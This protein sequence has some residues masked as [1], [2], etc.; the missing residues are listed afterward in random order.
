MVSRSDP[1]GSTPADGETGRLRREIAPL[2]VGYWSF[3]QYWGVWVIL[4]L[5]FLAHYGLS[6]SRIGLDY[7]VLSITSVAVMIFLTPRLQPLALATTVPLALLALGVGALMQATGADSLLIPAFIVVGLGNGLIDVFMNVAAQQIEIRTSRPVLQWMHASYAFGGVT[8]GLI[9]GL[10][11]SSGA[12]YRWAL[13]WAAAANIASGI[14]NATSGS[15]Q[16][17]DDRPTTVVS[18]SAFR[19]APMLI[20]PAFVVLSAFLVEGS[21]DTWSG[22]FLRGQLRA[23]V[24]VAAIAFAAFASAMFA[25][26]LFASRMLFRLGYKK[27]IMVAGAASAVAGLVAA[28]TNSPAVAGLAFLALGFALSSAAPAAFGI[29]SASGVDPTNAIAAVTTVG[30]S[31]FIWSPPLLG[32]VAQAFSLRATMVVQVMATLGVLAGGI[33]AKSTGV[34]GDATETP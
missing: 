1:A 13:V 27:T 25:G 29:V 3:G 17:S 21:M 7:T 18:L 2:L 32:W 6:E 26:R 4:V 30:Y 12:S 10:I 22:L 23:S 11:I 20:V 24:M 31:G 8:G 19:R 33:L 5:E 28:T 14:W 15:R 34:R 16:R 9:C